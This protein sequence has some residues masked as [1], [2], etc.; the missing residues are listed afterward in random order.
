MPEIV[1]KN[2]E[3]LIMQKKLAM[4]LAVVIIIV[5]AVA[6]YAAVGPLGTPSPEARAIKIGLVAPISGSPIGQDM[7]RAAMMAVDEINN[8]GG[9]YVSKWNTK[10]NI[11]L[12][13]ADT[14]N[15]A[16]GNAK[17]PVI[18]AVETDGVDLLI[19]GYGSA[20]TL[21]NEIVAIENKVPYII[22]G[23]SNEL[24]ISVDHKVTMEALD[25]KVRTALA[26]PKE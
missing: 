21:A 7:E 5:I 9:V 22:A 3:K 10:V 6:A 26:T 25:R 17:T 15:D 13:R 19:G 18:R 2:L 20:G 24:V 11:T 4:I 12:I 23:A 14:I 8:A 1:K 16:P